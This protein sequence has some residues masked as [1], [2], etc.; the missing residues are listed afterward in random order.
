MRMGERVNGTTQ[1][2]RKRDVVVLPIGL[3][4]GTN[5]HEERDVSSGADAPHHASAPDSTSEVVPCQ[6]QRGAGDEV[7][8][9]L[10]RQPVHY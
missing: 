8:P 9:R 2:S 3:T 6:A 5:L 4:F 1:F 7:T 10:P